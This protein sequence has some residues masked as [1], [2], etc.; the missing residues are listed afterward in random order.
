M[1][2]HV[3]VTGGAGYIGSHMVKML[4]SNGIEVTTLDNLS[5]GHRNAVK[6]GRFIE[7]DLNNSHDLTQLFQSYR[8]DSVMHFSACSLVGESMLNPDKYFRN[9]VC[10]TLNLLQ[11]MNKHN[12]K[13]FIFSSSAAVYGQPNTELISELAEKKPINP[14]GKSKLIVELMLEDFATAYSLNSVSLR[15]FN[16][17]GADSE[18]E[19]GERHDPETHLIPNVLKAA[20]RSIG[21]IKLFGNDYNTHDGTCV[22]DY[23]HV[24]DL[25]NAHLKALSYLGTNTGAFQFNLG[26]S[27]GYSVLDILNAAEAVVGEPIPSEIVGR[28]PGDPD[29]LV[30][31]SRLAQKELNWKPVYTDMKEIIKTAWDWMN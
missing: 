27:K 16:A 23:I 3:L 10:G 26:N 1:Y 24:E 4:H 28:R 13:K 14:Y 31:D 21:P 22:R 6:Y 29:T 8:F 11:E 7:G 19:L 17:A 15:Y 25:C 20:N 9:N 5:T 12:V 18:G 30:A 2:K